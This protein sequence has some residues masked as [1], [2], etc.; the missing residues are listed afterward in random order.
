MSPLPASPFRL[1][2]MSGREK[3]KEE[4]ELGKGFLA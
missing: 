3:E 4:K 2:N 1:I